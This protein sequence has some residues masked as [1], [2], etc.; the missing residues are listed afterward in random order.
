MSEAIRTYSAIVAASSLA[1]NFRAAPISLAKG[2]PPGWSGRV[3]VAR[4]RT[5]PRATT[6]GPSA[7]GRESPG[8][9]RSRSAGAGDRAGDARELA[10]DRA[11]QRGDHRDQGRADQ[12]D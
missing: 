7:S 3:A 12:G 1:Q 9:D 8:P 10:A 6:R 2:D 11:A 5:G 4:G